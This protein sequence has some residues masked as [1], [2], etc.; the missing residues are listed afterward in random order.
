MLRDS[1]FVVNVPGAA[2]LEGV[3][4][5]ARNYAPGVDEITESGL[6]PIPARAVGPPRIEECALHIECDLDWH[7]PVGD[8]GMILFCGRIVAASGDR[9]A[10]A[11]SVE[12]RMAHVRPIFVLPR[13]ID[14]LEMRLTGTGAAVAELGRI[15]QVQ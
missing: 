14:T 5:T 2:S 11:G 10:L 8:A 15:R 4:K 12:D 1:E 3:W 9:D 6:T 13:G 7:R